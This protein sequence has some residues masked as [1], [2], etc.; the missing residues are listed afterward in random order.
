MTGEL[1][2]AQR[3]AGGNVETVC[4]VSIFGDSSIYHIEG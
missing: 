2:E 1:G 4:L 3:V